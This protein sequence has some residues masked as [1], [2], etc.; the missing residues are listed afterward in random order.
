MIDIIYTLIYILSLALVTWSAL[1]CRLVDVAGLNITNASMFLMV[2]LA[3][4]LTVFIKVSKKT[5]VILVGCM[6]AV[7]LGAL[8]VTKR[9]E[10]LSW[11]QKY[12]WVGVALALAVT[13]VLIGILMIRVR[14]IKIAVG[15]IF[16]GILVSSYWT[17]FLDEKKGIVAV[18]FFIGTL[19]VEEIR[20]H[21][22][23]EEHIQ[24]YVVRIVPFLLAGVIALYYIPVSNKPYDWAI[25]KN[26]VISI[27]KKFCK[28]FPSFNGPGTKA[29]FD[30][31]NAEISG[32]I[33]EIG[34]EM[35]ELCFTYGTPSDIYLDGT[36]YENFTGR[37]W[38]KAEQAYPYF[39]DTIETSCLTSMFDEKDAG[40][41]YKFGELL[42]TY[43][44]QKTRYILT[45]EKT[46]SLEECNVKILFDGKNLSF[47]KECGKGTTYRTH[48]LVLNQNEKSLAAFFALGDYITEEKWNLTR[49]S[50]GLQD[51]AYSYDAFLKYRESLYGNRLY[52]NAL[53]K[54]DLSD[55]VREFL[56]NA[57]GGAESDYE[58]LVALE[59]AFKE[60]EYT[61]TPGDMP[62]DVVTPSA[63]LD[64]F[65]LE[66][67][68]GYCTRFA[69]AFVLL[70]QVEG[71]PARYVQGYHV[72]KQNH[73]VTEVLDT[74]AHA[75][76]EAYLEGVGW[77]V[78][79]P[80]PGYFGKSVW[81]IHDP[82]AEKQKQQNQ[83]AVHIGDKKHEDE[84]KLRWYMIA[85]PCVLCLI[86]LIV[87]LFVERIVN[88]RHVARLSSVER[89]RL[90]GNRMM[91]MLKRLG[92]N[93][94]GN[95]TIREYAARVTKEKGYSLSGFVDSLEKVLYSSDIPTD[96]ELTLLEKEYAEIRNS[97][98]GRNKFLYAI[99]GFMGLE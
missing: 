47:N 57:I 78:F 23:G 83:S 99:L 98:K 93:R 61:T 64:Y 11:F 74:D 90:L 9:T 86:V 5:K 87:I 43:T 44:G 1:F 4:L 6:A 56:K 51:E 84:K 95:E 52:P 72:V 18:V 39:M 28:L 96:E 77:M 31:N 79:E 75:Y 13:A 67:R 33:I 15:V 22:R 17:S 50:L 40:D 19:L 36:Y 41:Y 62:S 49:T 82:K 60:F 70:C 55:G 85:V 88:K 42:V 10:R 81:E 20:R 34:E 65:I 69:T 37:I 32:D 53:T 71:I 63:F 30:D 8:L 2:V 94:E 46:T 91:R 24:D 45:P 68:K 35:L 97:L 59:K 73:D 26:V 38:E 58:K 3:V 92:F 16:G 66:E 21:R 54:E 29:G 76:P 14:V 48:F 80:T 89:T 27:E 25:V 7:L 12:N